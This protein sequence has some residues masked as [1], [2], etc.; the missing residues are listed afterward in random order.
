MAAETALTAAI[1]A[2]AVVIGAV[3][4]AIASSYSAR[5]KIKEIEITYLQKLSETYLSNARLYTNSVYVPISIALSKLADHYEDFRLHIDFTTGEAND[6]SKRE[7]REAC[8]EFNRSLTDLINQGS[9]AFLT[10]ALE[11]RLRSF[12][13]FIRSSSGAS[14]TRVRMVFEYE[15]R[16]PFMPLMSS[17]ISRRIVKESSA[18]KGSALGLKRLQ[19]SFNVFGAGFRSLMEEILAAPITS[20]EFEERFL[21]DIAN[22]KFLIKEVTL[23]AQTASIRS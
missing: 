23:G 13:S 5:Q 20:R 7:F 17:T 10:T 22:L 14:E 8:S 11:H 12:A 19:F 1:A 16:T 6:E 21:T 4:T 15:I 2:A 18:H 9:D 3:A